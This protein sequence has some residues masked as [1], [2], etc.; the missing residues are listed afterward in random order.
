MLSLIR[1]EKIIL[2]L[3]FYVKNHSFIQPSSIR[4]HSHPM[5][6]HLILTLSSI[7]SY[8][9]CLLTLSLSFYGICCSDLSLLFCLS[10]NEPASSH[11][12][13]ISAY[14]SPNYNTYY[15]IRSLHVFSGLC[16]WPSGNRAF[17]WLFRL[18]IH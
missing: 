6:T 18:H 10:S 13:P 14:L 12:C 4:N 11:S 17:F 8:P 5:T 3:I 2:W 1:G 7:S 15:S 9:A 16:W